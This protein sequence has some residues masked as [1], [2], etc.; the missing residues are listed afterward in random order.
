ME[1]TGSLGAETSP[2]NSSKTPSAGWG[3]EKAESSADK[4][5]LAWMCEKGLQGVKREEKQNGALKYIYRVFLCI[6]KLTM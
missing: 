1:L 3:G 4:K 5:K 6:L 2:R